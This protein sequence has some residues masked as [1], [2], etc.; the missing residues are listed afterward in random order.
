LLRLTFF[1]HIEISV[2][3]WAAEVA[4]F[5]RAMLSLAK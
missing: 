3:S 2:S 4:G 5:R 1:S